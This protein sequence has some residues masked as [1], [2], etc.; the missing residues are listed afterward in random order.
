MDGWLSLLVF[1]VACVA[2]ASTG[3]IFQPGSWYRNLEKPRWNPPDWLFG[4]VW[5]VLYA[6]IAVS[7]WLVWRTAGADAAGA[8]AVYAVQ[9]LLNGA[10]SWLFFGR[11]RMDLA[12]GEV[13]LLWL[14][15]AATIA[16]FAPIHAGAA[17]MLVPYLAWVTLAGTLNLRL[18]Q[19]NKGRAAG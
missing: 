5:T 6:M 7:G 15:I 18:L 3:A 14:S 16:V 12:M 9:L 2:V 10:W 4:P 17:W 11:K 1:I 19:L 8:L 13:V